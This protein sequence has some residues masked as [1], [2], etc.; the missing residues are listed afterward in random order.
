MVK[1]HEQPRWTYP[2]SVPV[3]WVFLDRHRHNGITIRWRRGESQA[4]VLEGHRLG[5]HAVAGILATIPVMPTGWTDLAEIRALGQKW[6]R[7]R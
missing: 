5:D 2:K 7:Q 3:G 6:L 4:Y 1:L